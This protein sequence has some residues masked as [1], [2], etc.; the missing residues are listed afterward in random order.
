MTYAALTKG[1]FAIATELLVAAWRMGL[2]AP[3]KEEFLMSQAQRY[4]HL[5]NSLPKIPP[6][7]RRWVGEME[8]IAKTFQDLDMTPKIYQGAADIY[9]FMG[10]SSLADETP[11]TL[12]E[13]RSLEEVI[14]I[15]AE[16][17]EGVSKK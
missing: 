13:G 12:D 3:L 17:T 10:K 11:E 7:S 5:E 16:N 8:E 9:R 2:Y 4:T 1:S 14:R 6:K 15:L